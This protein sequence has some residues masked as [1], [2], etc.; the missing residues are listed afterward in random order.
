MFVCTYKGNITCIRDIQV[1][2]CRVASMLIARDIIGLC[3][4]KRGDV[5]RAEA[6]AN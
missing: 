6:G 3:K 1:Q 2:V 4:P 5:K